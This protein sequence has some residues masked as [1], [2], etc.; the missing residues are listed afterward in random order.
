[1]IQTLNVLKPILADI[2]G[3]EEED[4]S[5]ATS[6]DDLGADELDLQEIAM[7]VEEEF[8]LLIEEEALFKFAAVG[9]LIAYI[10]EN[11]T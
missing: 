8:D 7:V 2:F 9:D 1:M 6:F 10:L 4:I 11:R 3:V 5:P